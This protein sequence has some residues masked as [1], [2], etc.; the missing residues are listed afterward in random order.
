MGKFTAVIPVR[1]I[2]D[3]ESIPHK[4]CLP[5]AGTN[6][7]THKIRQLKQIPGLEIVVSTESE[8]LSNIAKAE[9]IRVIERPS[10]YAYNSRKFDEFTKYICSE[11]T[12]D[13]VLWACVTSPLV[14]AELYTHAME[15][16]N[17]KLSCGYDSLISV[18]RL[19]RY[20]MDK[21]GALNFQTGKNL[22]SKD[23]L[24]TLYIFTN[25]ISIAPRKKMI[26]WGHTSGEIPYMLELEKREA[27]DICDNFDYECAKKF[28]NFPK[29][30]Y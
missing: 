12:S 4:D 25:G 14:D 27:I 5:F 15:I 8:Y 13:N 28:K 19:Q 6:L 22:K 30:E 3:K 24:P 1:D 16:Y 2:W 26:E 23:Q 18:Q 9:N 20:L 21:N 17:E 29:T 11:L 7:L 10:Q